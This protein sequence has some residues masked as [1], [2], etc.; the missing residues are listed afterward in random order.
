LEIYDIQKN[1]G[2]EAKKAGIKP[3]DGNKKMVIIP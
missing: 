1:Q 3:V 2:L